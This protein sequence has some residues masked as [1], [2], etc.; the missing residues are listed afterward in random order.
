MR[1]VKEQ[2]TDTY[3]HSAIALPAETTIV[4]NLLVRTPVKM[5]IVQLV[6]VA[7]AF[8]ALVAVQQ[9]LVVVVIVTA[10]LT[11]REFL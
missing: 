2:I 6:I 5:A 3:K 8:D 10:A 11:E 1:I 7:Q 9:V 4:I